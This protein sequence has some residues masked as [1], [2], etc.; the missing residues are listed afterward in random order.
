MLLVNSTLPALGMAKQVGDIVTP[1]KKETIENIDYLLN[2]GGVYSTWA[3]DKPK[4]DWRGRQYAT[5]DI[6]QSNTR[7]VLGFEPILKADEIDEWA[8][9]FGLKTTTPKIEYDIAELE[10]DRAKFTFITESG[11]PRQLDEFE[12]YDFRKLASDIFNIKMMN[13]WNMPYGREAFM[14]EDKEGAQKYVNKIW[15][16]A[17]TEALYRLN[18]EKYPSIAYKYGKLSKY[19]KRFEGKEEKETQLER[20]LNRIIEKQGR[21]LTPI[22]Y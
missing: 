14:A 10:T 1:V 7:A 22:N 8:T 3:V 15:N 2:E 17:K 5:G 4:F 9:D 11:I 21:K 18:I 6:Y 20:K 19:E 16:D 12:T 13:A